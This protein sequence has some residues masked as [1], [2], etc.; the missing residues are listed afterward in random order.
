MFTDCPPYCEDATDAII[1]VVIVQAVWKD[2][3]LSIILP[4]ITVPFSSISLIFIRQ[5]LKM[6]CKK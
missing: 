1:C 6:G 4:F 3:G 5:Q 2:L